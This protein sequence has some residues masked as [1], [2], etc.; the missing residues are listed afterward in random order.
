MIVC[1]H[2]ST[3]HRAAVYTLSRGLM[4]DQ[5]LSAGGDGW[6][7]S[8][9]TG[10]PETGRL[11]ANTEVQLYALAAL[12]EHQLIVAGN[13]NGGIHWIDLTAPDATRNILH[14][15]KGVYDI[16]PIG[17]EV[18]TLGGDGIVSR[19][20]ANTRRVK[21]SLQLT[22]R[23]LRQCALSS[24]YDLLAIGASDGQIYLLDW[25]TLD[26][27]HT[28]KSAHDPAVF[29]VCWSPDGRHLLSG[30][31]DA[32]L[33]IWSVENGYSEQ[34]AMPAHLFT[35]NHLTYAPDGRHFATASRDKTIKI[36]DAAN[37]QL[38]K[39][40][41]GVRD[42]GHFNSVNH[43]LWTESGL[44]SCSDDRVVIFW[45]TTN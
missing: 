37:F 28:I 13:F 7:V 24:H 41:E 10:D 17:D 45:E 44:V 9:P 23:A 43:L 14:H 8:W 34:L 22:T 2:Q 39:V 12:P 25:P 32:M 1:Q 42:G 5:V 4:P 27:V 19:W 11:L 35:I 30:G 20:E 36:W 15:G 31:R 18:L 26:L 29:T 6:I 38:I 16:I 3:G 33:R 40:L 21:E